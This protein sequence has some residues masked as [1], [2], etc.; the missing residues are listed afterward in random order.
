MDVC[1]DRVSS[2]P[3]WRTKHGGTKIG[4]SCSDA[5]GRPFEAELF[6]RPGSEG[7]AF[8]G[9]LVSKPSGEDI[10][11]ETSWGTTEKKLMSGALL[12]HRPTRAKSKASSIGSLSSVSDTT[13][14]PL[15]SAASP[16]EVRV[17]TSAYEPGLPILKCSAGFTFLAGPSVVH[18][19]LSSLIRDKTEFEMWTQRCV[20]I[21][22][23]GTDETVNSGDF[24]H[25]VRLRPPGA[26][27]MVEFGATCTID[28]EQIRDFLDTMEDDG[29][30][31]LQITF[32]SI[33]QF[34]IKRKGHVSNTK[35]R[36][37]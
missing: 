34:N 35:M 1:H 27:N 4:L 23:M 22:E 36:K 12:S 15:E 18:L 2:T 7:C 9:L 32:T 31:D 37:L 14:V 6:I 20:N 21:V 16:G 19:P 25:V 3:S 10:S 29:D 17:W 8:F 28:P 30:L 5:L 26:A 13:P 11:G 24:Q 33:T